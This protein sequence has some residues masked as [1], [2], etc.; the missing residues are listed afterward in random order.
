[1]KIH[2][3][4]YSG[5]IGHSYLGYYVHVNNFANVK[6]Q[7]A[8]SSLLATCM[9]VTESKPAQFFFSY[10]KATLAFLYIV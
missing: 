9:P 3:L 10:R 7:E 2:S 1:M 4:Y 6:K 8:S 5:N